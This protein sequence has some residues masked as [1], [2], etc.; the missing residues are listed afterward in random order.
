MGFSS[1]FRSAAKRSLSTFKKISTSSFK[2]SLKTTF[3]NLSSSITGALKTKQ[4]RAIYIT[5]VSAGV[6]VSVDAVRN[7]IEKNSTPLTIT[8]I[9]NTPDS[10]N[11]RIKFINEEPNKLEIESSDE[12]NITGTD[13]NPKI[14]GTYKL[15]RVISQSE[16]EVEYGSKLSVSGTKGTILIHT[17]FG[18]EFLA[19]VGDTVESVG[20]AADEILG[21]AT[22]A[23]GIPGSIL[24]TL[25]IAGW[26][27][28][29]VFIFFIIIYG[30]RLFRSSSRNPMPSFNM[31]WSRMSQWRR[32]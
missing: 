14:D 7:T 12:F 29:G 17:T 2:K 23:L 28:L 10:T 13:S 4:A 19:T 1:L 26:V 11:L 3:K 32:R 16:V 9:T 30:I 27:C 22:D 20:D 6:F 18:K 24:K 25:E 15:R 8:S 5:A 31:P 21:V